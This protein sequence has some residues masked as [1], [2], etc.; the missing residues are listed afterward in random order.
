[1]R[2]ASR[3]DQVRDDA[4]ST[5]R[6]LDG[7]FEKI[8]NSELLTDFWSIAFEVAP[9]LLHAGVANHFQ[10][11]HFREIGQNLILHAVGEEGVILISAQVV[12][13]QDRDALFRD[14]MVR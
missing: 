4:Q 5:V 9:V 6:A 8:S 14:W 10:V 7:S 11:G 1:L 2:V 3:I 12:E 13:R